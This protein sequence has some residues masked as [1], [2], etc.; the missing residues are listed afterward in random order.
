MAG[1]GATANASRDDPC[2][3]RTTPRLTPQVAAPMN[4]NPTPRSDQP[5]DTGL[6]GIATR[7]GLSLL[8]W[9]AHIIDDNANH[10]HGAYIARCGQH[11]S[12]ATNL[13]DQ[14]STWICLPCLRGATEEHHSKAPHERPRP[15]H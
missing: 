14:P 6:D 2:H 8:D 4:S 12:T 10:P 7:W 15:A 5:A 13:D 11:L 1:Q 9:H 3:L